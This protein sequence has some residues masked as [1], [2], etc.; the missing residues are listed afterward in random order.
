[1]TAREVSRAAAAPRGCA[2]RGCRPA[3][4]TGAPPDARGALA[5]TVARSRA[6]LLAAAATA[7]TVARA[8]VAATGGLLL[9]G[10]ADARQP[11]RL[12]GRQVGACSGCEFAEDLVAGGRV[13]EGR[14]DLRHAQQRAHVVA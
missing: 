13:G 12:V 3:A 10:L 7:A 2:H 4:R 6:G 11:G 8:T 5:P 1:E 14:V 9:G